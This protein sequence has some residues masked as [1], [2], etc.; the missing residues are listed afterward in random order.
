[1]RFIQQFERLYLGMEFIGVDEEDRWRVIK[2]VMM[3]SMPQTRRVA[4]EVLL[5]RKGDGV[6]VVGLGEVTDRMK[7]SGAT[8]RRVL[9]DLQAHDIVETAE[10]G[11][12]WGL[13]EWAVQRMG[14]GQGQEEE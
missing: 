14:L 1:M 3:D 13:T 4:L 6:S 5:K 11:K 7:V 10:G 9:E 12:G 2:K 8:A